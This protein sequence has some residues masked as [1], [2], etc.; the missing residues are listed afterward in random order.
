MNTDVVT[1]D[2]VS[3]R[4]GDVVA[5]NGLSLSL[6][7]G[8]ILG[9]YGPSGSGKT[10]TIRLILGVYLPTAGT[11]QILGVPST[12]LGGRQ[13]QQIG[14]GPQRFLYPPTLTAAEA[15]GYAAGLY[16]MGWLKGPRAV[17]SVLQKVELWDKRNR[18]LDDMSGGERRRVTNAAALVHHPRLIFLDEPTTGL[19]P[20]LRGRTWDWFRELKHEGRTLLVTGHYLGEAELCDRLALL[21]GGRLVALGTP[22][23]LRRQALGG[24]VV[25]VAVEGPL[26]AALDA[27]SADPLVREVVVTRPGQIRV[28]VPEAGR[29]L[30]LLV[31]RLRAQGI[32]VTSANEVRPPFDEIF[33]RLVQPGV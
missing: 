19:D 6:R 2:N 13:R 7:S 8:E 21:V 18:R 12:R 1:L 28:T 14:Y 33:E 10:T 26:A 5:V 16:G 3:R 15:V 4:F 23:E 20:I 17:R 27:L 30:P 25:E 24:E 22:T 31:G 32:P 29:A 9:L 11:V